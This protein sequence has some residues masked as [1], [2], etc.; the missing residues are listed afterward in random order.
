M[1]TLSIL[2]AHDFLIYSLFPLQV[3]AAASPQSV[4]SSSHLSTAHFAIA[5]RQQ[6]DRRTDGRTLPDPRCYIYLL[7]SAAQLVLI[8][9]V[10]QLANRQA[11][12]ARGERSTAL[13]QIVDYT[14]L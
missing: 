8:S 7:T 9:S 1:F 13:Q 6:I 3:V 12:V 4:R 10:G 5:F 11:L 2:S 14:I